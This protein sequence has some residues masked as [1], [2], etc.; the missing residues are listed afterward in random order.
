MGSGSY[1]GVGFPILNP[2]RTIPGCAVAAPQDRIRLPRISAEPEGHDTHSPSLCEHGK[3]I[4]T[5]FHAVVATMIIVSLT[6]S[7][8]VNHPLMA[9]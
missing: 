4:S 2:G 8:S 9:V 3:L 7:M 5:P 1:L 6:I